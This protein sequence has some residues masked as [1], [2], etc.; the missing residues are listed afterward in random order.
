MAKRAERGAKPRRQRRPGGVGAE[1]EPQRA[2]T[3]RGDRGASGRLF[4]ALGL[5]A[6]GHGQAAAAAW[7]RARDAPLH[8]LL[9]AAVVAIALTLP[10]AFSLT[11]ANLER[12]VGG[13]AEG[14]PEISLFL[15]R[16]AG[17]ERASAFAGEISGVA[18]VELITPREA[19]ADL[20]REAELDAALELLDENPLPSV[21]VA[22]VDP[23]LVP[24]EVGDLARSL[25]ERSLVERMRLDQEWVERLHALMALAERAW[26]L[27]GGMLSVAVALAIG[28]TIR[29]TI[30]S[31]REE[32]EIIKLI[33]GTNPFV[34]R[35]FL[36]EGT[37]YGVVGGLLAWLLTEIGRWGLAG[38]VARLADAYGTSFGLQGLGVMDGLRLLA[39]GAGLG[40][41]GAWLAVTQHLA[42]IEPRA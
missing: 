7:A 34:R 28:N 12:V 33:G 10:A 27:I 13:W 23:S 42:A 38:P 3:R 26:W 11:L 5:Y 20:R 6:V 9:T 14:A 18:G 31:R 15:E 8:S 24:A 30:E 19:L 40:L 39:I 1:S 36:Y 25:A 2:A 16:D 41:V 4:A 37:A 32:I 21:V 35:P 17:P 22:R 29:L